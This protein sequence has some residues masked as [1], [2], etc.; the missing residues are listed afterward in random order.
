MER[1]LR[2]AQAGGG[3]DAAS[4][5]EVCHKGQIR[6]EAWRVTTLDDGNDRRQPRH[7]LVVKQA[8]RR[9]DR[10]QVAGTI[11]PFWD[12]YADGDVESRTILLRVR[13]H[14]P[15]ENDCSPSFDKVLG[16]GAGTGAH[17]A[18][19]PWLAE[20]CGRSL[21]T[22]CNNYANAMSDRGAGPIRRRGGDTATSARAAFA[23]SV[24]LDPHRPR[25]A[26]AAEVSAIGLT[27]ESFGPKP[28]SAGVFSLGATTTLFD[29]QTRRRRASA[30]RKER[31]SRLKTRA[32][33]DGVSENRVV[34][35][36]PAASIGARPLRGG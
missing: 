17:A 9:R 2:I 33:C 32:A 21:T 29:R 31:A 6:R 25:A 28:G 13:R 10:E 4:V 34:C 23:R 22:F 11:V 20:C 27:Q 1:K 19:Q 36:G 24:C 18:R 14:L 35:R 12:E 5:S 7:N 16:E 15:I 8:T 26:R 3:P 30:G